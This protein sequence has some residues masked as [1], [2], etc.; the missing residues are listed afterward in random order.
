[1]SSHV[2]IVSGVIRLISVRIADFLCTRLLSL[3]T[4]IHF[5]RKSRLLLRT[6]AAYV[7]TL[8]LKLKVITQAS[9]N[10]ST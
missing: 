9:C 2:Y 10:E 5:Q 3:S 6:A 4:I 8:Q 1:M 7:I